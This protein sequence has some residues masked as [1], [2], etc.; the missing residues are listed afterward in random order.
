MLQRSLD[1]ETGG[2]TAWD[3]EWEHGEGETSGLRRRRNR[4]YR[5]QSRLAEILSPTQTQSCQLHGR[6]LQI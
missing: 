3:M 2:E 5:Q 6:G 1:R 4:Q